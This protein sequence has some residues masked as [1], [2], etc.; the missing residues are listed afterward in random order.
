VQSD[1]H[2]SAF[3]HDPDSVAVR[4][5]HYSASEGVTIGNLLDLTG[6]G[7]CSLNRQGEG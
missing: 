2:G 6:L 3:T 5:T 7:V 1:F 4:D